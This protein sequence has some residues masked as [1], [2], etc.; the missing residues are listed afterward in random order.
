MDGS[1]PRAVIG[2]NNPPVEWPPF[3]A[4]KDHIGDLFAE[5]QHHLDGAGVK[6]EAE[7]E[8]IAKLL[9]ALR[10]AGKDADK[11]RAEEKRPHDEAGKAV[12]AKWKPLIERAEL[13]VDVCKKALAPWL[14]AKEAAARAEAERTRKEAEAKA[15]A[16]AEAMRA[17]T[18]D[19]L[20]GRE[21]AEDLLSEAKAAEGRATKAEKARPQAAGGARATTLR[22]YFHP[23]LVNASEA[24]KH[25]IKTRPD[26]VKAALLR[27][28]EIEVQN[29]ARSLPG[30]NVIEERR[31]V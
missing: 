10:T 25:F 31:V 6:S 19:D 2:S 12:Q 17:T 28:A 8:A 9:D 27:L 16:A 14:M 22:S 5:A 15:L 21:Q 13:A 29:G 24:L 20:A 4:F 11:A 23:E 3:D 7:A 30:F 26:D 1:N 18:L